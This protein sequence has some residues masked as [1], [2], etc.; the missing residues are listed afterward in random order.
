MSTFSVSPENDSRDTFTC[1][2]KNRPFLGEDPPLHATNKPIVLGLDPLKLTD[3]EF[4]GQILVEVLRCELRSSDAAVAVEHGEVGNAATAGRTDDVSVHDGHL[5]R[6]F[7][8]LQVLWE[9]SQAAA[10][11]GQQHVGV[12]HL[13]ALAAARRHVALQHGET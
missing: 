2:T 1:S 7:S 9:S 5:L 4:L 8:L 10:H 11:V 3:G 12:L 6:T 13:I